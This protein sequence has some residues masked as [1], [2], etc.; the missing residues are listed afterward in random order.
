MAKLG[1]ILSWMNCR[2]IEFANNVDW[3]LFDG[4]E[5]YLLYA[6]LDEFG[7]YAVGH[8]IIS[9]AFLGEDAMRNI[10]KKFLND[11]SLTDVITFRGDDEFGY[12]G[13]ICVSPEYARQ[14]CKEFSTTFRRELTLYLVH[15]YLHLSG[16]DDTEERDRLKMREAEDACME[17]AQF[18]SAIPNFVDSETFINLQV[19]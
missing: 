18:H 3:L 7:K 8:G 11:S 1:R 17:L 10:H 13:E 15:G 14:A 4:E 12:A 6:V 2:K 5:L 9:V 19:K 16:L